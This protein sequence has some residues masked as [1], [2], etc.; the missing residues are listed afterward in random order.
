M[1]EANAANPL[2]GS[3]ENGFQGLMHNL[4]GGS[5]LRKLKQMESDD[6]LEAARE[7]EAMYRRDVLQLKARLHREQ[8]M[9]L[10]PRGTFV[11]YWDMVTTLAIFYCVFVT[12][13]EIGLDLPT[14]VQPV[15]G[16][17]AANQI[18]SIVFLCDIIVQFFLPTPDP[19]AAAA[20]LPPSR[21]SLSWLV[22]RAQACVAAAP[23]HA[24]SR[25]PP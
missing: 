10:N 20:P 15:D 8:F 22:P 9:L 21:S 16:L 4:G 14:N 3:V 5:A 18:V 6:F 1:G 25:S 19:Y 7:N 13:Y 2:S 24:H 11:Q 23:S 12:P 17:C